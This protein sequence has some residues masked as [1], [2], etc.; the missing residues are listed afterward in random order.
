MK[1]GLKVNSFSETFQ[2]KFKMNKWRRLTYVFLW[3][4]VSFFPAFSN[5]EAFS[6]GWA[7]LELGA[8]NYG[9]DGHTKLSQIMTVLRKIK[10]VTNKRN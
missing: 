3:I 9:P 6:N 4:L 7:H 10:D 1:S 2:R 5:A 8:G